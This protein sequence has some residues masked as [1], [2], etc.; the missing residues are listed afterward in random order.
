MCFQK[1]LNALCQ[2]SFQTVHHFVSL[3]KSLGSDYMPPLCASHLQLQSD[4]L[5]QHIFSHHESSVSPFNMSSK[6][7]S[8]KV[9]RQLLHLNDLGID[10]LRHF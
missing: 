8:K 4:L 2:L 5:H 1:D 10:D 6:E 3:V 9:R 7:M